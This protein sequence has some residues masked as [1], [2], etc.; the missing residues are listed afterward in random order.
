MAAGAATLSVECQST[1][2]REMVSPYCLGGIF[3]PLP[4]NV[5]ASKGEEAS[6]TAREQNRRGRRRR[7]QP[8][9]G[10]DHFAFHRHRR[11]R[12]VLLH[13]RRLHAHLIQHH[14]YIHS[15]TP[16][17]ARIASNAAAK[18]AL[19]R[20]TSSTRVCGNACDMPFLSAP[21]CRTS[22]RVGFMQCCGGL[23]QVSRGIAANRRASLTQDYG[24]APALLFSF[25]HIRRQLGTYR[26]N[27]L[28]T[29]RS[30]FTGFLFLPLGVSVHICDTN[31]T[32][33][34][35]VETK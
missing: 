24:I 26:K 28:L 4:G 2:L 9:D 31:Q 5:G 16:I 13:S 22:Y 8:T 19:R 12:P 30:L 35:A 27:I 3:Q 14:L 33:R 25:G 21:R 23:G 1:G 11:P 20:G 6:L 34:W 7:E 32:H 15:P 29:K 18:R 17:T 10:S